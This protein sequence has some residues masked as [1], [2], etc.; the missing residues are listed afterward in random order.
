MVIALV[1]GRNARRTITGPAAI[2]ISHMEKRQPSAGIA[3]PEIIGPVK[4]C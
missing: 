2:R 1:S 4:E 3:K